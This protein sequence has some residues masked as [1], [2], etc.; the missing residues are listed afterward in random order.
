MKPVLSISSD[1]DAD[2]L[3]ICDYLKGPNQDG[4]L[5]AVYTHSRRQSLP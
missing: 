4:V 3:I 5:G 2:C 1:A